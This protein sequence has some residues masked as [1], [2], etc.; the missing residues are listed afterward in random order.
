MKHG[1][2]LSNYM[3]IF[4]FKVAFYIKKKRQTLR[5][6]SF[7]RVP[8]CLGKSLNIKHFPFQLYHWDFWVA[9]SWGLSWTPARGE[10]RPGPSC[11]GHGWSPNV[12][13]RGTR[14]CR[15]PCLSWHCWTCPM[16]RDLSRGVVQGGPRPTN[17]FKWTYLVGGFNPSEKY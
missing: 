14:S 17:F 7:K 10:P 9:P 6:P 16:S 15:A 12:H 4:F 8:K 11:G 5:S 13:C 1:M 3:D 2:F